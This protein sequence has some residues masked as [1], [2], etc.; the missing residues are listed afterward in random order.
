M[1]FYIYAGVFRNP[2]QVIISALKPLQVISIRQSQQV[3]YTPNQQKEAI[4]SIT[5]IK[6]LPRI[7]IITSSYRERGQLLGTVKLLI[8]LILIISCPFYFLSL[9]S[10]YITNIGY[11]NGVARIIYYIFRCLYSTLKILLIK[12]YSLLFNKYIFIVTL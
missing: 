2:I 4:A 7:N 11:T 8:T 3:G 12:A 6:R 10:F 1:N 9:F 5:A